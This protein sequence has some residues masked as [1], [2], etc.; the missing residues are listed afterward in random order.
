ILIGPGR[1]GS[2]G[3]IKLGVPVQYGDINNTSILI[4]VARSRG[5]YVPELSFG[6]HFFQDLVEANIHYLPL[7][8]EEEGSFLNEALLDMSENRIREVVPGLPPE[9]SNIVK[10]VRTSDLSGGGSMTVVMDGEKGEALAYLTSPDHSSW[11]LKKV[12]EVLS[13]MDAKTLGVEAVY[14]IGSVKENTAGPGSDIDLIV[15]FNGNQ[16]QL[17]RLQDLIQDWSERLDEEN[18]QRTNVRTGGLID[19]HIVTHQDIVDRTSWASHIR[20]IYNPARKLQINR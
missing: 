2:R 1:W 7:Y 17:E 11:R 10:V 4:E 19:M 14:L 8:P 16:T 15:L 20:S 18:F 6:T 9:I 5:G 3:D 13:D 12:E